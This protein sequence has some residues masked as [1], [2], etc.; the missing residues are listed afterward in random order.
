MDN[1][2]KVT[3]VTKTYWSEDSNTETKVVLPLSLTIA[4][5]EMVMFLGPS[6]CGKGLLAHAL[7]GECGVNFVGINRVSVR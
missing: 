2:I 7:A 5:G 4:E 1:F 3:D 6:G